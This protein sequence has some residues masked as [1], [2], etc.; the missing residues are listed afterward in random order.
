MRLKIWQRVPG[1]YCL[2]PPPPY[3]PKEK[4]NA[5]LLNP[6]CVLAPPPQSSE[7]HGSFLSVICLNE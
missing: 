3:S 4:I 5:D 6:S 7:A 1:D 2:H